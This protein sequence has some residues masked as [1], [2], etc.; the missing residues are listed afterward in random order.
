MVVFLAVI[1]DRSD[2]KDHFWLDLA[3]PLDH[4][5]RS[6]IGRGTAPNGAQTIHGQLG[7]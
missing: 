7:Y 6:E 2:R 3:E 4:R 5:L 1:A